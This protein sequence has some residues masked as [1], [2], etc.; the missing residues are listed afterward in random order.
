M[1][2][3]NLSSRR[4]VGKT[5]RVAELRAVERICDIALLKVADWLI[6]LWKEFDGGRTS[7][8]GFAKAID[9]CMP[10]LLN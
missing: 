4:M 5:E 10:I 7:E 2:E 9:Q 8:A 3:I 1:R 6:T